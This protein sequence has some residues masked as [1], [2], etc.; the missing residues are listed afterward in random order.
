MVVGSKAAEVVA[1]EIVVAGDVQ[2]GGRPEIMGGNTG[3]S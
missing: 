2:V 3:R 1:V